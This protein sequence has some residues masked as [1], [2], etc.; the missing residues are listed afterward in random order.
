MRQKLWWERPDLGY[1]NGRLHFANQ[2]LSQFVQSSQTPTFL[3]S[4]AR[5]RENIGRITAVAEKHNIP[6]KLF[7]AMKANR[8]LPLLTYIKMSGLCGIDACSP[9]EM[10][11]ARQ[12]GFAEEEI[13][14]TNTAVSNA[15]LD[16]L[17]RHPHVHVNCDALSTIRR[18]G[19][20][21]PGRTIGI[22][23][24]PQKGGGYNEGLHY[25]GSKATKFGIYRDRF[26]EA[27]TLAHQYDMKVNT[28]HFHFGSGY[29]SAELPILDDILA[30]CV[31][32]L[33]R[34]PT[35]DTIDVGGGLG[36][37][38]SE[39]EEAIDLDRWGEIL[40]KF[41][42][43]YNVTICA[44]PGDFVMKD[45]GALLVEVNTVEEKG[46]TTFVGVN[47]GFNIQ[48]LMVY[49]DTPFII[50]PLQWEETAVTQKVT[51]AGHINEVIGLFAEDIE[52]PQLKEGD[53]LALLNVGGYG[54]A[55]SSNHCMRGEFSE[56]LVGL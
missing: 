1:E 28:L 27:V 24:N 21:C 13:V 32:F 55:S 31:W 10:L 47:A 2:D 40:G 46:G 4:A 15:D 33:E 50:V 18:L 9:G 22:R 53:C 48:N 51:I 5:V 39:K 44:E 11:L 54:V 49:Y 7:Y 56:Y 12:V 20:R 19:E 37:R 29:L 3:Y 52:L 6:F 30:D 34:C 38:Y 42:K 14:Y 8:Y 45:S 23:I 17:Q 16:V 25:A 26:E 41:A 36:V 43:E 35:I